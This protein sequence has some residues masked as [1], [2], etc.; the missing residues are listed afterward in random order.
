MVDKILSKTI[1]I[2]GPTASGKT[3]LAIKLAKKISGEIISADSRAVYRGV[4]IASAKPSIAEQEGVPH[5]GI[6]LVDP[7]EYFSVA[8]YKKYAKDKIEEIKRRGNI[9]IVVGGT[10]LYVDALVFDYCFGKKPDWELRSKMQQ[11]SLS[12]L[13]DYCEKNN[14]PL[15]ENKKN[16]KYIIRNIERKGCACEKNIKNADS[17]IVVGIS[18][19]RSVLRERIERRSE[20]IFSP[21]LINEYKEILK[22]CSLDSEA[23]KSNAYPIVKSYLSGSLNFE[24]AKAKFVIADWRLAKRQ[25]TWL[26]RNKL[27]FWGDVNLIEEYVLK[28]LDKLK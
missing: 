25:L 18:T 13:Y 22:K 19:E 7:G 5:W 9:P 16:K 2:T 1:V 28:E 3:S 6:D 12:E 20:Q 15:P 17:F 14:I 27:I 10:G 8:D 21:G 4:D 24:Q 23:F 26:R 11:L